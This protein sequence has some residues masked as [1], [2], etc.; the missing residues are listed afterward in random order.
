MSRKSQRDESLEHL[1]RESLR[2]SSHTPAPGSCPDAETLAA[3]ADGSLGGRQ[4]AAAQEHVSDCVACQA[5]LA[6]LART[7]PSDVSPEPWWRRGLSARWLVPVA[8]TATALAI[9]V[10][11][12]R[13][14]FMRSPEPASTAADQATA[15]QNK[16]VAEPRLGAEAPA[17]PAADAPDGIRGAASRPV[18]QQRADLRI[19]AARK[20]ASADSIEERR[21]AASSALQQPAAEPQLDA[22]VNPALEGARERQEA[23]PATLSRAP[24]AAPEPAAPAQAG[25]VGTVQ[26]SVTVIPQRMFAREV[27]VASP[28]TAFRWRIGPAGAVEYSTDAGSRWEATS[29][30]VAADLTAGASPSGTVCWIVGRAGTVLLTTDGR[31][32]RRLTFPVTADLAAVQAADARTATVTSVDGRRFRTMD[33]GATWD[34]L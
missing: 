19:E 29:S 10:A 20:A 7:T 4:L 2:T 3:W 25:R 23:P 11:V 14:E 22:A 15:P 33:A 18:E 8:A 5:T 31:Q 6:V 30:G 28:G 16:A 17:A 12:P 9:W 1:L 27:V 26:E 24:T 21:D 34:G 32:W 13:D